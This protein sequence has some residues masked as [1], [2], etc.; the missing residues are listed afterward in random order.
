M[1]EQLGYSL[2]GSLSRYSDCTTASE[3][4]LRESPEGASNGRSIK[5]TKSE[6]GKHHSTVQRRGKHS[7]PFTKSSHI[8]YALHPPCFSHPSALSHILRKSPQ[9][10][11]DA[12]GGL[13]CLPSSLLQC[14]NLAASSLSHPPQSPCRRSSL[15][16]EGSPFNPLC[17]L[18]PQASS[19]RPQLSR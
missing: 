6:G 18:S 12:P 2:E 15:T 11:H 5:N 3:L 1:P 17:L 4:M 13:P 7:D 8:H 14:E 19:L 16:L 10:S 9:H